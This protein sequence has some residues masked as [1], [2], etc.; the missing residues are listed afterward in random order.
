MGQFASDTSVPVDKTRAEIER[1]V[2]TTHKCKRFSS[3]MDY[4]NN[5]AQVQFETHNRIVRFVLALP[6]Q[7]DQK[8][9]KHPRYTWQVLPADSAKVRERYEQA[10]RTIWRAL[11]LVIKAKLE[12]VSNDIGTFENEFLANI[13]MPNNQTVGDILSPMIEQAYTNGA[14]PTQLMLGPGQ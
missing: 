3:G 5:T 1:L 12:A 7:N 4:E 2:T 9:R 11:L 10:C 8:F 13:V 6:N 14:M